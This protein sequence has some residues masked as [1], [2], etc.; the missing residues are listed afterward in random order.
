[1][2]QLLLVDGSSYLYRAFH[3]MPD[4]RNRAGE[5]TGAIY[6]MVNMLKAFWSSD[7]TDGNAQLYLAC[8]FDAPGKNFRDDWYNQYKANR[9]A[10]PDDLRLQIVDI[11]EVV[12]ALGWPVLS[13]SGVEA[14]DVIGTLATLAVDQGFDHVLISTGDKDMAQLVND[15]VHLVN[16]MTRV[17]LDPPGVKEKFGVQPSQI[18]DYLSLMGDAVD[19]I[20]G[21]EKVGPKTSAKWITTYGSLEA[22]MAQAHEIS[23]VVGKN[24]RQ[25]LDWL[26]MAKK[27]LTIAC[28]LDLSEQVP[29]WSV[30]KPKAPDTEK[31]KEL[32]RRFEFK[33]WFQALGGIQAE[34]VNTSLQGDLFADCSE[35][36]SLDNTDFSSDVASV[37]AVNATNLA[38]NQVLQVHGLTLPLAQPNALFDHPTTTAAQLICELVNTRDDLQRLLEQLLQAN[39]V[40]FDTETDSLDALAA[41]LVGLAFAT[42]AGQGFYIPIAHVQVDA[43]PQMSLK[44]ILGV[45]TPW[46]TDA[47]RPKLAQ[48]AKFDLHV[49]ATHGVTVAGLQHD[50]MLQSYVLEAHRPHNMD[51]LALR[52]INHKTMS[53]E[54]VVGKK[55][56]QLSFNE[57][58]I[59]VAAIYSAEDAEV[60]L[61]LHCALYPQLQQDERLLSVYRDIEMPSLAVLQRIEAYGVLIDAE[62]LRAQSHELSLRLQEIENQAYGMAGRQFNLNSPKQVGEVL[63]DQLRLPVVKKTAGGS[64]ST[65]EEVLTQLAENYSLPKLLLEHRSLSKLKNT[66]T[67]KLPTMIRPSTGRVH[68]H[69][70]QAVAVTGRL[71]SNDPNLQN[72]PI[73]TPEGRR[74][75]AAFIASADHVIVSADYSQI[76]LR[77][78]AHISNDQ[79]LCAAFASGEDVHRAT[80]SEIFGLPLTQVTA[81]QRRTAKVINFGLIYGMSAFGLAANLGITRQA[82][83]LYID[84]YFM[85]YPGVARYMEE[86]REQAKAQQY[87][88]TVFGRRLWLPE[89]NSANG[90]R[91]AAAERAAINAPMQGTAADLIKKAMIAIDGKIL[92]QGLR[93]RMVMQVHDEVVL[94]VPNSELTELTSILHEAMT[95]QAWLQVPLEI[96]IGV[97]SNWDEA[98]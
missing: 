82:A 49:L 52:W 1:M 38:E 25:S 56:L 68:T 70:A 90:P 94:E 66:Y 75:R 73:R 98:H 6:G 36:I 61:R 88:E 55:P 3:A 15:K 11:Y 76:E 64:H 51:F 95:G 10:M 37:V 53:Y 62:K 83:R 26:P 40:C 72:I 86:I 2:K 57:V 32:Y 87:V 78:M 12:Q 44:E 41:N 96:N 43:Q 81:E 23:G 29:D 39:L 48:N 65:S 46:F 93:S 5:P 19:N 71:T 50:T 14:D 7:R 69:Y 35:T 58:P 8:V 27:L 34:P 85:R 84:R 54:E 92:A 21:V 17:L 4:L 24:L 67:D 91:R 80:A 22:V 89:I 79:A 77:I 31:L 74:V 16:T 30:L 9:A 42:Q 45:L 28:Q 33:T 63:F 47:S 13:V 18:V 59:E 20:P 60:T 97:G